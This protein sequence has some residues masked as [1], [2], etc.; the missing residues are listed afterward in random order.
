[1]LLCTSGKSA[2]MMPADIMC[3]APIGHC[4][5]VAS[6]MLLKLLKRSSEPVCAIEMWYK[7]R[8]YAVGKEREECLSEEHHDFS[9]CPG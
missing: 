8:C 6:L 4:F 7:A 3:S 9:V 5:F 1:M 2:F